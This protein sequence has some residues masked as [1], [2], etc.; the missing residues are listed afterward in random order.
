MRP[1]RVARRVIEWLA[2]AD[3]R[4]S[5]VDDLDDVFARRVV[6]V[7]ARRARWWY[8]RQVWVGSWALCGLQVDRR[9]S[10]ADV[11][12]AEVDAVHRTSFIGVLVQDGRDGWR[13][14]RRRLTFTGVAILSL[15]L[16]IGATTAMFSVVNGVL[17]HPLDLPDCPTPAA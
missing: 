7:G 9:S 12:G 8:R 3:L 15:A 4:A 13:A 14:S 17:L 16:G 2:P 5:I 6:A 11:M 1:P 10:L